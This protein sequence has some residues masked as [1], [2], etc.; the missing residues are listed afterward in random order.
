MTIIKAAS[1]RSD[2]P[3]KAGERGTRLTWV[4]EGFLWVFDFVFGRVELPSSLPVLLPSDECAVLD[5]SA[6]GED[7]AATK[8]A[9]PRENAAFA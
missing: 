9:T 3:K 8:L 5:A 7:E 4:D 2:L 1:G 6:E